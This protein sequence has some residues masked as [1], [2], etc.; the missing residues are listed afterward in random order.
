MRTTKLTLEERAER[1]RLYD[2]A[3]REAH[4]EDY[5][6]YQK[7]YYKKNKKRITEQRKTNPN[8]AINYKKWV[9]EHREE[10]NAYMRDYNRKKKGEKK[11]E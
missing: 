11:C 8:N 1:K 4:K 6:D 7:E 10:W 5:L 3:Y 9:E 2:I